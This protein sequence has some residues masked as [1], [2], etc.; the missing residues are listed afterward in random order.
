MIAVLIDPVLAT[1]ARAA[2]CGLPLPPHGLAINDAPI[3]LSLV[4]ALCDGRSAL[5]WRC[6]R[7]IVQRLVGERATDQRLP[8]LAAA[9]GTCRDAVTLLCDVMFKGLGLELG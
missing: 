9:L 6:I 1:R 5:G 8:G 2:S 3:S 7:R 4:V